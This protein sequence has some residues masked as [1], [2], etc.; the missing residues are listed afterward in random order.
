MLPLRM[1][2]AEEG[3]VIDCSGSPLWIDMDLNGVVLRLDALSLKEHGV[4]STDN[5][6]TLKV[7]N[8]ETGDEQTWVRSD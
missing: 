8:P 7:V 1:S 2:D 6:Q 3:L 5:V 4:P